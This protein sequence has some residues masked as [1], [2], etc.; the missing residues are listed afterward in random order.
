[1][2]VNPALLGGS[3]AEELGPRLK[4][5]LLRAVRTLLQGIAGA[6]PAAGAGQAILEAGYWETLYY[7]V[8]AAGIAALVSLLQN[9]ASIFPADPTQREA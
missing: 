6:F 7:S 1:M 3:P 4:L 9:A 2:S 8:L 5:A